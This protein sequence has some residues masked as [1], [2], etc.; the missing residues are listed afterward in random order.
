M[1]F[2]ENQSKIAKNSKKIGK[3]RHVVLNSQINIEI[4]N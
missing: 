1:Y 2:T 4:S 3:S